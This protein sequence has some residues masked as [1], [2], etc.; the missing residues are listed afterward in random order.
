M[1]SVL[2]GISYQNILLGARSIT[3]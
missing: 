1:I 3:L 2:K